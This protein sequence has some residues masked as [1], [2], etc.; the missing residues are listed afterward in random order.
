[1][2]GVGSRTGVKLG[3]GEPLGSGRGI[4]ESARRFIAVDWSGALDAGAQRRGIWVAEC[5]SEDQDAGGEP[6]AIELRSGESRVA[7]EALLVKAAV[8]TPEVVAGI[9]FSFS[10]PA[11]F[12]AGL[13]CADVFEFWDRVAAEGERWLTEPHAEFWGRGKVGRP[14]G[15]VAPEWLGYRRCELGAKSGNVLPRSSFQI[16][17]AGAVGTGSLRGIPMLARL[18][19]AGFHV[20]PFDPPGWPLL[21]EIYPRLLTGAVVKS[22]AAA[23]AAYLG[24]GEFEAL[25]G[26]IRAAAERSEDAFDALVSAWRMRDWAAGWGALAWPL[27]ACTRLEGAIWRPEAGR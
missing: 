12:V 6:R 1:V 2:T 7:V 20:W 4:A 23:R 15:H 22:R 21:V 14:A 19:R 17:G 27:D 24:R 9:D 3:E 26:A 5:W 25:P 16:G 13:G 10:Y 11:G 18:R 8:E